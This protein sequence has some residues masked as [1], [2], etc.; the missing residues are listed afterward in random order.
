MERLE[1]LLVVIGY[2]MGRGSNTADVMIEADQM[3]TDRNS[4]CMTNEEKEKILEVMD[5]ITD[6]MLLTAGNRTL[7][8]FVD[9]KFH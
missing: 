4:P 2:V 5:P 7:R 3:L 9:K 6:W 8:R 1:F